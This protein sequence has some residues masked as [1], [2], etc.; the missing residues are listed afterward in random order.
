MRQ[1][2]QS[3][4]NA[5]FVDITNQKFGRLTAIQLVGYTKHS[6]QLWEFY[7]DCGAV[8]TKAANTVVSDAKKG[9]SPGC[10]CK[11]FY[12]NRRTHG[13]HGTPEYIIWKG[14]RQRC[15]DTSHISYHNY[16]GRGIKVCARWDN[17]EAFLADMGPRPSPKH[18]IDRRENDGDYCPGNC[19]W[20][21]RKVQS[22]NKRTNRLL[23]HDGQ[24]M[25]VTDWAAKLGIKR[26]TLFARLNSGMSPAKALTMKS[27]NY[28]L[29]PITLDGE[30][31]SAK[32]W[33]RR[34][35]I[36]YPTILW[37]LRHGWPPDKI[38]GRR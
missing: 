36:P 19:F 16:G 6:K 18:T 1:K 13:Q 31:L 38:L 34:T 20:A 3:K 5:R 14:L 35:G 4:P 8:T 21:T 17:F 11:Q 24:T 7:C 37:R 15:N 28:T 26:D 9:R 22:R 32:A 29:R 10:G 23:T 2:L 12:G 30:T 25:T 27:H 33:S